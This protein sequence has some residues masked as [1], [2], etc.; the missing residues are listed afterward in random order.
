[1]DLEARKEA[2]NKIRW[3]IEQGAMAVQGVLTEHIE[4]LEALEANC[5][6]DLDIFTDVYGASS[7]DGTRESAQRLFENWKTLLDSLQKPNALIAVFRTYEEEP[8]R[9]EHLAPTAVVAPAGPEGFYQRLIAYGCIIRTPATVSYGY[10]DEVDRSKPD[11]FKAQ[12]KVSGADIFEFND[13]VIKQVPE[14]VLAGY[15]DIHSPITDIGFKSSLLDSS[16]FVHAFDS[17]KSE[18]LDLD[19]LIT[20]YNRSFPGDKSVLGRAFQVLIEKL[21]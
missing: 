18:S 12:I 2:T 16:A 21:K 11:S 19:K 1:M 4:R 3:Q 9:L 14:A 13:Y 6:L 7:L 5:G 20:E 10:V 8:L 17:D 15:D